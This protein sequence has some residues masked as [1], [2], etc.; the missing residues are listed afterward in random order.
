MLQPENS[1]ASESTS[2][3][4]QPP[5]PEQQQPSTDQ[6]PTGNQPSEFTSLSQLIKH[7]F[8]KV[9]TAALQLFGLEILKF[10]LTSVIVLLVVLSLFVSNLGLP[11]LQNLQSYFLSIL[12]TITQ[13]QNIA[14]LVFHAAILAVLFFVLSAFFSTAPLLCLDRSDEE[15]SFYT[16]LKDALYLTPIVLLTTLFVAI[17]SLGGTAVLLIPGAIISIL[18]IFTTYEVVLERTGVFE[19]IK[20]SYLIIRKHYGHLFF[21]VLV[22]GAGLILVSVAQDLLLEI[23]GKYWIYST[24]F[25]VVSN[26]VINWF[27]LAYG[28]ILYREVRANT[29][30]DQ[31]KNPLWIYIISAIGWLIILFLASLLWVNRAE[32][33]EAGQLFQGAMQSNQQLRDNSTPGFDTQMTDEVFEYNNQDLESEES[34]SSTETES[35]AIDQSELKLLMQDFE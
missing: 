22:L 30:L 28:L 29:D 11:D 34:T 8:Q 18:L 32:F 14:S 1:S 33:N 15:I 23:S 16:I 6:L 24:L 21:R 35:R 17:L 12:Q 13:S 10:V 3:A 25:N 9:K 4:A 26:L 2:A 27:V 31:A 19:A 7:S 5:L 20:N